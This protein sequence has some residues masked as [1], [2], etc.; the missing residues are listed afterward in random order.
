MPLAHLRCARQTDPVG[1]LDPFYFPP[2]KDVP[3]NKVD[4]FSFHLFLLTAFW[5]KVVLLLSTSTWAVLPC[6][7]ALLLRYD[8][9][10]THNPSATARVFGPNRAERPAASPP[11]S[12]WEEIVLEFPLGWD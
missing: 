10:D 1:Q 8:V 7:R 5:A 6:A 9:Q 2:S 12:Y 11:F 3:F 4:I